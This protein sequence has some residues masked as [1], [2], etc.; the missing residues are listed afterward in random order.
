MYNLCHRLP[1]PT[2]KN[3]RGGTLCVWKCG[4]EKT[5]ETIERVCIGYRNTFDVPAGKESRVW[6]ELLKCDNGSEK[7]TSFNVVEQITSASPR[8]KSSKIYFLNG[9]VGKALMRVKELGIK[10]VPGVSPIVITTPPKWLHAFFENLVAELESFNRLPTKHSAENLAA[11]VE[12]VHLDTVTPKSPPP[13]PPL[14]GLPWK[15][16]L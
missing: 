8:G 15:K 16:R 14:V 7:E 5:K 2:A 3:H 10:D 4:V 13:S 6:F 11:L 9:Y 12:R 1:K